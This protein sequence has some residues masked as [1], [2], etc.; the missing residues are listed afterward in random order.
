L[1]QITLPWLIGTQRSSLWD[2]MMEVQRRKSSIISAEI[3]LNLI[4]TFISKV[5][6]FDRAFQ[7]LPQEIKWDLETQVYKIDKQRFGEMYVHDPK[8]NNKYGEVVLSQGNVKEILIDS[9][10]AAALEIQ[11]QN[12]VKKEGRNFEKEQLQ[13][14]NALLLDTG[15]TNKQ[16]VE[17]FKRFEVSF[18]LR[19]IIFEQI[20]IQSGRPEIYNFGENAFQNNPRIARESIAKIISDIDHSMI[21]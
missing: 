4:Q 17:A 2:Q 15:L 18:E 7:N 20:W 8:Y 6:N 12:E 13:S 9:G 16:L 10:I 1:E 11:Y 19:E 14:F 5:G 3:H 21:L